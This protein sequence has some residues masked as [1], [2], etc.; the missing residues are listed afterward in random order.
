MAWYGVWVVVPPGPVGPSGAANHIALG[1]GGC[2]SCH[3]TNSAVGGFKIGTAPQ[4]A[5]A[6]HAAVSAPSGAS[7]HGTGAAWYGVPALAA[8]LSTH[9][10]R[11]GAACSSC[12]RSNLVPGGVKIAHTPSLSASDP[13]EV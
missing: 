1:S 10:P 11:A 6:G 5:A 12:H 9:M 7:C 4:L 13:Q 8:Q 3:A 2:S